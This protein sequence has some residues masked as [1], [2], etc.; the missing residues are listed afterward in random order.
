MFHADA[1][2]GNRAKVRSNKD[3]ISDTSSAMPYPVN[4]GQEK[5]SGQ[6]AMNRSKQAGM[7]IKT[8]VVLLVGL[9]L[10]GVHLAEAQQPKRGVRIG[11]LNQSSANFLSTQLEAFRQGLRDFGYVEGQNI[12]IE[13]RY[14]E[15]KL[16]HLAALAG[17][18]VGPKSMLSSPPLLL[19]SWLPK[20]RPTRSP[21]FSIPSAIP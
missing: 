18:L 17:E 5:G 20:M 15:G 11:V 8:I 7:V 3:A 1:V 21:L 13:Y 9:A 10:A 4:K 6:L 16:D 12:A 14:A 19:E 2:R